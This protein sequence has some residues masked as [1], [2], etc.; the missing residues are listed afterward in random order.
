MLRRRGDKGGQAKPHEWLERGSG[1]G[2][3]VKRRLFG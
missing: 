3:K 1:S 2:R